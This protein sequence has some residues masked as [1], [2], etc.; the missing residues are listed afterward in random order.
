MRARIYITALVLIMLVAFSG[1]VQ[2]E[3]P[4]GNKTSESTSA[5]S[6]NASAAAPAAGQVLVGVLQPLT[7]DLATYGGPITEAVRLA[8]DEVNSNGGAAG[9]QIKLI[10]EDD[11]TSNIAAADAG[12]KLVKV[13]RV[14]VVVGAAGSGQS[15]S[16]IDITTRNGVLQISSSNSGVEFT[17]YTDNDLYF[18][19]MPS[20]ALQGMALAKL[21]LERGYKTASTIM[22]NN[23]YGQGYRDVFSKAF[24]AGGGKILESVMYDPSQTVFDSEVEKVASPKPDFILLVGYPETGSLILRS[25]YQ[26]GY[27]KSTNWLMSE[28]LMTEKLAEMVGKDSSGKYI[29]AGMQGI[30]PDQTAGGAAYEAFRQKFIKAYGKEPSIFCANSYDAM[31]V[32]ALAAQEAK[33]W[34]GTAIR[35]HIR[36]VSNPGGVEVSDIGQALKLISEGKDINYQGASG[37]ITFDQSG[38]VSAAYTIWTIKDD[39]T[40]SYGEKIIV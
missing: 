22:L 23:P 14:P 21:A 5:T 18:R 34:N 29:V 35:D 36:S 33:S 17:N 31:A 3:A 24:A 7:G 8:A 11:Q 40:I 2:K 26:R 9:K 30:A 16:I 1:C 28:G 13:D 15:M 39:G 20:D 10:V 12:N 6:G 27:L 4:E 25:A 38:D 19:T 37:E 32:V